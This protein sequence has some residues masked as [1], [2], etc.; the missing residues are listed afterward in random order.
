MDTL[1]CCTASTQR[2]SPPV[3][4]SPVFVKQTSDGH[5]W[6]SVHVK[7]EKAEKVLRCIARGHLSSWNIVAT[8]YTGIDNENITIPEDARHGSHCD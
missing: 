4:S 1:L 3:T 2:R 6:F 5:F 8:R 7:N